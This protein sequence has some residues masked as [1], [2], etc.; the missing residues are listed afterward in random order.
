MRNITRKCDERIE[1]KGTFKSFT[2][3]FLQEQCLSKDNDFEA[4]NVELY[5]DKMREY[6]M[7]QFNTVNQSTKRARALRYKS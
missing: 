2:L 4:A 6:I 7:M 1:N 5:C 3:F